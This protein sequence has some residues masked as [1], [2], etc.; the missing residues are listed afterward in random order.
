MSGMPGCWVHTR[1]WSGFGFGLGYRCG[2][3]S[4]C[5]LPEKAT[6]PAVEAE[7][8]YL[9]RQAEITRNIRDFKLRVS[10]AKKVEV[11]D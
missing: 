4:G 5:T 6:C 11:D 2:R 1:H 8:S 9:Q 10:N 3:L 7:R